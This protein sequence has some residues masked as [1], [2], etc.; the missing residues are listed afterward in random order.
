MSGG[1]PWKMGSGPTY[2]LRSGR[3][4][5]YLPYQSAL[6]KIRQAIDQKEEY[7]IALPALPF[8]HTLYVRVCVHVRVCVCM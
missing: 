6:P 1:G 5:P 2:I 3:A 8:S 7:G 4:K